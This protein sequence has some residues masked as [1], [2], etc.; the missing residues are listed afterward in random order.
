M[1]QVDESKSIDVIELKDKRFIVELHINM[2][3]RNTLMV[4]SV[5]IQFLR[6][7]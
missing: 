2:N 4:F 3:R 1:N 5:T 6:R 7:A